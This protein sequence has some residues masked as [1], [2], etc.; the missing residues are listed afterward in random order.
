[1]GPRGPFGGARECSHQPLG[2]GA[3]AW[4]LLGA[5]RGGH[6]ALPG[7]PRGGPRGDAGAPGPPEMDETNF[8][9]L[10]SPPRG[11]SVRLT[12]ILLRPLAPGKASRPAAGGAG[13][14][15]GGG[16]GGVK[17]A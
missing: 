8:I 12:R 9:G 11:V 6:R 2:P 1:M 5:P 10:K 4:F 3:W 7:V 13:A 16:G 15:A 17:Q 14:P